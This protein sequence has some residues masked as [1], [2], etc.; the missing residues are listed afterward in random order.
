MSRK[1]N[2]K[3]LKLPGIDYKKSFYI[4][5]AWPMTSQEYL[6]SL[7]PKGWT[8]ECSGFVYHG[9]CKHI[10]QCHTKMCA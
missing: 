10:T 9:K 7:T 6:V 8:C 5:M 3:A 2:R 1:F 4:G